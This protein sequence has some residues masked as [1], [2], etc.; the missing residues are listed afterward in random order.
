MSYNFSFIT[1]VSGYNLYCLDIDPKQYLFEDKDLMWVELHLH[2]SMYKYQKVT[3]LKKTHKKHYFHFK[4]LRQF[5]V[6]ILLFMKKEGCY[7]HF[8]SLLLNT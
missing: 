7:Y 5:Q 3:D 4:L 2:N 8:N 1:T 6:G